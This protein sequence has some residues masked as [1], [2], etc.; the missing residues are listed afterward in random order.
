V[1]EFH[2]LSVQIDKPGL[3]VRTNMGYYNQPSG[4]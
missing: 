2:E 1:V 3:K 4:N